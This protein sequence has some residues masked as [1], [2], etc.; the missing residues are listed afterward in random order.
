MKLYY[1]TVPLLSMIIIQVTLFTVQDEPL[2]NYFKVP[3]MVSDTE[4][5]SCQGFLMNR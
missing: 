5:Y 2:G 4:N 1:N 3:L